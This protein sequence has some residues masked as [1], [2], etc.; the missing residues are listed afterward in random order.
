MTYAIRS[1][2]AGDAPQLADFGAKLFRQAYETTHPDPAL[3]QYLADSFAS[4]RIARALE[5]PASRIL[6]VVSSDGSWIGYAQLHRGPPTAPT[7]VLTRALPG[8]A[9][10]EIVRFYVDRQWHG[11]GIA[12]ALMRACDEWAL[13]NECDTV[14]L[15]AWE[16]APRALGFYRKQGFEVCG[17]AVFAFGER[18]DGDLILARALAAGVYDAAQRTSPSMS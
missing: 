10:V 7:T 6:V 1:A 15:Q 5:D 17:T 18:A 3:S 8:S 2:G 16:Q 11:Q 12:Q 14:W 13:M 4:D 9:P